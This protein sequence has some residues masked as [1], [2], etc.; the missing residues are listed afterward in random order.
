M[1]DQARLLVNDVEVARG[2]G[3]GVPGNPLNVLPGAR[4]GRCGGNLVRQNQPY[5]EIG[6]V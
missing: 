4:L 6:I 1:T 2:S 3:V 5:A